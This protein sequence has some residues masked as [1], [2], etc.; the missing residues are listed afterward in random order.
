MT[1]PR[2]SG[3]RRNLSFDPKNIFALGDG[4]IRVDAAK[5]CS[6]TANVSVIGNDKPSEIWNPIVIVDHQRRARLKR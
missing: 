4:P 6:A 2:R 1:G 5:N 3:V